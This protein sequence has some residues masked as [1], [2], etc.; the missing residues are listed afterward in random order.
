MRTNTIAVTVFWI[1]TAHAAQAVAQEAPVAQPAAADRGH[2]GLHARAALGGGSL[3]VQR[4]GDS[5]LGPQ[6]ET[7]SSGGGSALE[8]SVGGGLSRSFVLSGTLLS[9]S[10]PDAK[11]KNPNGP[12][13]ELDGSLALTL[14]GISGDFYPIPDNG[15]HVFATAGAAI[16]AGKLPK[17]S[18]AQDFGIERVGG[19]GFGLSGGAGWEKNVSRRVALGVRGRVTWAQVHGEAKDSGE[20]FEEDTTALAG[21][22][23]FSVL[24]R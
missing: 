19:S 11:L 2:R 7:S 16:V 5:S 15:L 21:S 22:V 4:V 18:A 1:A 14:V 17:D 20:T 8:L 3:D 6:S 12:D 9:T 13:T 23:A 24:F 10:I